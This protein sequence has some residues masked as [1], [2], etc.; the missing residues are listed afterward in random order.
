M[1]EIKANQGEGTVKAEGTKEEILADLT[2]AV[3]KT[4]KDISESPLDVALT[5]GSFIKALNTFNF[6][7]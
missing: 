7:V 4:I 6:V 1:L 3:L 5:T 2:L